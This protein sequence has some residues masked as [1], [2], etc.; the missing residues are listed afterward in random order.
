MKINNTAIRS[1]ITLILLLSHS[2]AFAA[3]PT[4]LNYQGHLTDSGG[5]PSDGSV[6]VTFQIYNVSAGGLALWTDTRLVTVNHG[7]FSVELGTP[8]P[9]PVGMFEMPL[10]IGITVES[11]AEMEPRRPITTSGYA[12]KAGDANTLEGVSASALDQS[13]HVGDTAN[14]HNVTATQTGAAS[15]ADI[16]IHS[17]NASAH[18][19]KTDS[20]TEL[21]G[22][23]SDAQ[24]P[25][26][27]ARDAEI[28]WTNLA[29]KPAG[30]ADNVDND[31]GGD[32]T[33]VIAGMG[34][35]G[36]AVSG[37]AIISLLMPLSL[38]GF[39]GGQ[40]TIFGANQSSTLGSSG[41]KGS[42]I[43]GPTQGYLGVQG[44]TTFDGVTGLNISGLEIGVLG[45]STGG[46]TTDNYGL[47]G[48]S[49]DVGLF[50]QGT[51]KAGVFVGDVEISGSIDIGTGTGGSER[52]VVQGD[53]TSWANGFIALK[54]INADTGLRLYD[55]DSTIRFHIFH[56][57][58]LTDAGDEL[59]IAPEDSFVSGGITIQ[60]NGHVGIGENAP[61]ATLHVDSD[62]TDTPFRVQKTGATK[63]LVASTGAVA[64]GGNVTTPAGRLNILGGNDASLSTTID[65]GYLVIGSRTGLNVVFDD[66]EIMARNNGLKS[67]L[68]LNLGS[69]YVVVPGLEITGGADLVEPFDVVSSD[70]D[71]LVVPGM[72]VSINPEQPGKL[73][74]AQN[75]Y[76]RTVAGIISGANGIN[77]GL[78]MAQ[79]DS[80]AD[81]SH[82]VALTGRLYALADASYGAIQPGDM[83]TTSDTLGHVMKVTDHNRAQGAI[84]GKAMTPLDSGKGHVLVLVSLQ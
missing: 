44:A 65:D 9:F 13:A 69:S 28:T 38:S 77:P 16:S 73:R 2:L 79:Q 84:I 14:P 3:L 19:S 80:I 64:I 56:D 34:L 67:K 24:I 27:I 15:T 81:G 60:Q 23:I 66:N 6:S 10:W 18:H 42:S 36:G 41:V 5:A 70:L 58:G 83:L 32:I 1:F 4:T 71:D 52:L 82:P 31:S 55:A 21:S 57:N 61:N 74:I 33:S 25:A 48:Y 11:D 59:R 39:N 68:Y 50:A 29:G 51:N 75:A 46:S 8:S 76:D 37:D 12:F 40:A 54:N 22:Q 35:I 26:L 45:L 7:V 17:S 62:G 78:S 72:V 43:N 20:F 47:Y 63:L 53:G 30:F 49:N